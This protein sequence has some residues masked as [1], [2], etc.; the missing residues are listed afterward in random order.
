MRKIECSE[1]I[2]SIKKREIIRNYQKN[3]ISNK[4]VINDTKL[5][6]TVNHVS[7]VNHESDGV[8]SDGQSSDSA[9]RRWMR[10]KNVLFV[11]SSLKR[12]ETSVLNDLED[13]YNIYDV[14]ENIYENN[15]DIYENIDVVDEAIRD[16]RFREQQFELAELGNTNEWLNHYKKDKK[17]LMF[18]ASSSENT[19]N[20]VNCHGLTQLHIA[21]QN[22][23]MEMC[24]L[25]LSLGA[26]PLIYNKNTQNYNKNIYFKNIDYCELPLHS[27]ARWGHV[28]VVGLLLLEVEHSINDLN[29]AAKISGNHKVKRLIQGEI[30]RRRQEEKRQCACIMQ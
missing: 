26:N 24:I 12:P 5:K 2:D 16:H 28:D 11:M 30:K 6:N 22:G 19:L 7:D 17:R 25:L 27:A 18:D 10:L 14:D 3:D 9:L 15:N 29:T 20:Q 21:A 4:N 1:N 23:N 13:I 8:Q